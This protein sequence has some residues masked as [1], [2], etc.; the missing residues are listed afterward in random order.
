MCSNRST[1]IIGLVQ[2]TVG[3]GRKFSDLEDLYFRLL[4]AHEQV[5][6]KE[7]SWCSPRYK[8]PDQVLGEWHRH[9]SSYRRKTC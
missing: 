5:L 6:L 1:E 2:G 7:P 8:F 3:A 9:L 4:K